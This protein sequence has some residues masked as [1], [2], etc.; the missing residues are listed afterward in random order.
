VV[1]ELQFCGPRDPPAQSSGAGGADRRGHL[2][3]TTAHWLELVEAHEVRCGPIN[4][5]GQ[6][7]ADS[8]VVAREMVLNVGHPALGRMKSLGSAIK[9]SDTPTNPRRRAPMMASTQTQ[10]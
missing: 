4:N 8:H 6:V 10:Y 7:F 3:T 2:P 5:Y 1:R 9:L